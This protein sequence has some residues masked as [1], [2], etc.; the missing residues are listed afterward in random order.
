[1]AEEIAGEDYPDPLG[2]LGEVEPPA[3]AVFEN[4]REVLW[5]AVASQMLKLDPVENAVRELRPSNQPSPGRPADRE[6]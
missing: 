6:L 4:A 3:A 2:L 1:M 5:S